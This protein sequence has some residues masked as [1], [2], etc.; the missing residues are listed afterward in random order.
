MARLG[1]PYP[2]PELNF[3]DI[4]ASLKAHD[5]IEEALMKE[6]DKATLENPVGFIMMFPVADGKAVYRVSSAKPLTLQHVAVGDAWMIPTAHL[7]GLTMRDV[8][9]QM[10]WSKLWKRR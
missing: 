9:Q 3:K 6:S 2:V 7:R 8:A 5:A 10:S 1:K 4:D